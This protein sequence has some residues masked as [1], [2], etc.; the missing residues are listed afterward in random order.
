MTSVTC[1]ALSSLGQADALCR[2]VALF[3]INT[4]QDEF[5]IVTRERGGILECFVVVVLPSLYHFLG[6]ISSGAEGLGWIL[7]LPGRGR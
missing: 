1:A 7:S 4:M 6:L 2:E 5:S 3:K